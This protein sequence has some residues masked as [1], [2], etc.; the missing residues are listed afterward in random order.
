VKIAPGLRIAG[1]GVL[2]DVGPPS[3][4]WSVQTVASGGGRVNLATTNAD[5]SFVSPPLPEGVAHDVYAVGPPGWPH[6]SLKGV[7]PGKEDLVITLRRGKT[8]AGKVED[9]NGD[10][11][12]AGVPVM[13]GATVTEEGGLFEVEGLQDRP[14]RVTAGGP[15]SV[16]APA[17]AESKHTPGDE[18]VVVTVRQG[19]NLSGRVVGPDGKGLRQLM[20]TV[21]AEA[22]A[23]SPGCSYQ[24]RTDETGKFTVTGLPPGSVT[25]KALV[26]GRGDVELG[27]VQVPATDVELRLPE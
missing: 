27:T 3:G 14:W 17:A 16:Y 8:L 18:G 12:P 6:A 24:F 10:P 20:V 25:L 26:P 19:V 23:T 7:L 22:T 13:G 5:G 21:D 11:V 15:P 2:E 1:R 9:E 4:E